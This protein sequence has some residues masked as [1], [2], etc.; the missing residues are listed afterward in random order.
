MCCK[1]QY[2][3]AAE[4]AAALCAWLPQEQWVEV[5]SPGPLS[6]WRLRPGFRSPSCGLRLSPPLPRTA[7]CSGCSGEGRTCRPGFWS[8]VAWEAD[9]SAPSTPRVCAGFASYSVS[10]GPGPLFLSFLVKRLN[11]CLLSPPLIAFVGFLLPQGLW[12]G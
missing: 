7:V 12:G 2:E 8:G 1:R 10:T 3:K 5:N 11:R 9:R 4:H 6:P